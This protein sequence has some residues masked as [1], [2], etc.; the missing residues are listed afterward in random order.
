MPKKNAK[1]KRADAERA[2]EWWVRK[3]LGCVNTIRA[4]RTKW[5]YQDL[6][7][8]DVLGK[9]GDGSH[10]YVQVTAGQANAAL[11]RRNKLEEMPWH[12]SDRVFLLRLIQTEDPANARKK[13]WF[14]RVEEYHNITMWKTWE[15]AVEIPK[16]WFTAYKPEKDV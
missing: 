1:S 15:D 8:A 10:V 13:K 6:F 2:T 16:L 11:K 5:Q 7:G 9:K 3:D 12:K 14:F 4:V